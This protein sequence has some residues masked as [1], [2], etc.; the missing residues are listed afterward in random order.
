M[1]Q[2][3]LINRCVA[4]G[5]SASEKGNAAVGSVIVKDGIIVGEG[6]E[7]GI[8]RNDVTCHAEIEA[9]RDA[10]KRLDTQD[11]SDCELYTSHEPC[12]MCSYAIRFYKIKKV[13]FLHAV[14]TLGGVNSSFPVLLTDEVSNHWSKPPEVIDLEGKTE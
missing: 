13:V 12:V 6:E 8:S 2:N 7:A 14:P 11:L 9:L 10:V 4:L 5:V 1:T 3:D